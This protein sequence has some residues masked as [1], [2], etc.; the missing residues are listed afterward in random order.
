MTSAP[1]LTFYDTNKALTLE[2]DA[3]DYGIGSVL[4][5]EGRPIAFASRTLTDTERN[6]AQ[7]EKEMLAVTYGLEKFHH[8]TFGRKVTV[9][10]DHKPLVAIKHK[11][12]YKAPRRLQSMFLKTQAYDY[13]LVYTPGTAIPVADALSRSPLTKD[14]DATSEHEIVH[15]LT[16]TQVKDKQ[17]QQIKAASKD[18]EEM[19][20]LRRIIT[21]GWPEHKQHIPPQ[22]HQYYSYRDELTVQ[23]GIVLRRQRL[24]VPKTLRAKL[25]S[26][27]HA[28]HLGINSIL[29]R[30]RDTLYWPGMSTEVREYVETCGV[31]ASMPIKQGPEP[32]ISRDVPER[33]W[34]RVG[35]DIMMFDSRQYLITTDSHSSFFEIDHLPD[36]SSETVIKKLKKIFAR[37]GIPEELTTDS[38]TQFTAETFKKF[39][40]E[41]EFEHTLSSPGNHRANGAAESAVKTAKRLLKRCKA[42]NEDPYIGLLNLRN[43]PNEGTDLSPVQ[44]LFGRRTKS[45]IPMTNEKLSTPNATQIKISKEDHTATKVTQM[46]QRCH[47]LPPLK[48]GQTVR[49]QPID[50][51]KEWKE[52]VVIEKTD[53]RTYQVEDRKGKK[54][55]RNRALVRPTKKS[56][57]HNHKETTLISSPREPAH[58]TTSTPSNLE[59]EQT[60]QRPSTTNN[61][62]PAP[63]TPRRTEPTNDT[64]PQTVPVTGSGSNNGSAHIVPQADTV[65]RNGRVSRPPQRFKDYQVSK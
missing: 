52:G 15:N 25:K 2:N 11:P 37:H 56:K 19:M 49:M 32:I 7:I 46:N 60:P 43:A 64:V 23:D 1:V 6:Y 17:T 5:Q 14:N 47:D 57:H 8:Y 40:E 28:G 58:P 38:G 9:V 62:D 59:P 39:T 24:V 31:C 55:K 54:Y 48:I 10:T 53:S 12:L 34:Q 42:A 65:T 21:E 63:Q 20:L 27:C 13:D 3:S 51:T 4:K 35:S 33:P 61:N 45:I 16:F 50:N 41:W 26:K 36:M 18:D 22:V 30:A 44:M 29:R